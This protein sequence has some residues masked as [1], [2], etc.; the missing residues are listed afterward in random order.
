MSHNSLQNYRKIKMQKKIWPICAER[1]A[2]VKLFWDAIV[3]KKHFVTGASLQGFFLEWEQRLIPVQNTGN[4]MKCFGITSDTSKH[5]KKAP[6]G[7][8]EKKSVN[9]ILL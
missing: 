7:D 5:R 8:Y 1:A 3:K 2:G 6:L 4:I 9:K